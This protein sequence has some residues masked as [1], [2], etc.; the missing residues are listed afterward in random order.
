MEQLK[1]ED[2]NSVIDLAGVRQ[3][4]KPTFENHVELKDL[5]NARSVQASAQDSIP[6][7]YEVA[8]RA[9]PLLTKLRGHFVNFTDLGDGS[10]EQTLSELDAKL[11]PIV[12]RVKARLTRRENEAE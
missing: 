4:V 2:E 11:S 8:K 6:A 12:T 1:P 5:E 7:P 3:L 9:T 10:Y